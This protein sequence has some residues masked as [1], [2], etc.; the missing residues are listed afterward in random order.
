MRRG[1][2]SDGIGI[3]IGSVA[4]E[5]QGFIGRQ[6]GEGCV[7]HFDVRQSE[8]Y[9]NVHGDGSKVM[10]YSFNIDIRRSQNYGK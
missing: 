1:C 5:F 3:V 2:G 4:D 7:G 6:V 8:R 9:C 10:V